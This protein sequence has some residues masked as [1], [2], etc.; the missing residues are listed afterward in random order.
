M[1]CSKNLTK[2]I[3]FGTL[4]KTSD[5]LIPFFYELFERESLTKIERCEQIAQ[6]AP[7][8]LANVRIAPF[9]SKSLIRS[10]FAKNERFA[11]KT[12]EQIPNPDSLSLIYSKCYQFASEQHG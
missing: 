10:F 3:F 5:S 6:V 12:D 9:F 8:K 7:Q 2:I 11:Q 1:I 4:K